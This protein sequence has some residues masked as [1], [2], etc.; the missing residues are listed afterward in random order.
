MKKFPSKTK[1][2]K[3][4]SAPEDNFKFSDTGHL[5]LLIVD[6]R[7][8]C[9]SV[10]PVAEEVASYATPEQYDIWLKAAWST[11][12]NRGPSMLDHRP[13]TMVIVDD[14]GAGEKL[15][16]R[17][18][19]LE[20]HWAKIP[21]DELPLAKKRPK[22][23]YTHAGLK[24]KGTRDPKPDQWKSV[25]QIGLN[26]IA[27]KGYPYFSQP[28][29]EADDWAGGT[30]WLKRAAQT[31]NH[32]S[33]DLEVLRDREV[34]LYTVDGDWQQL[35][36][37]GVWWCNTGPWLPRLR[38]EK[39]V[40]EHTA[41]RMKV[42]INSAFELAAA[43]AWQGD[44][45]DNLPEGSPLWAIDLVNQHPNFHIKNNPQWRAFVAAVTREDCTMDFNG[46]QKAKNW[47]L[48][49]GFPIVECRS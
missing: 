1:F 9:W 29:H 38:G 31:L 7:V 12:L 13:Y 17:T 45:S 6:F 48:T 33:K 49:N 35:V 18:T 19:E 28:G 27:S 4:S 5:P 24:Y 40:V 30:V 44:K 14:N 46:Y 43:K 34:F 37:H 26:Y 39:E 22:V 20:K 11:I 32:D 16:W 42:S 25:A 3:P 15:Y 8:L 10:Y 2:P 47:C 23:R 36:G 21:A 41:R